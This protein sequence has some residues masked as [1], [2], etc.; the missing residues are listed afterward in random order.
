[1]NKRL[2]VTIMLGRDPSY[3]FVRKSFEAYASRVGA[4]LVCIREH[5]GDY[6]FVSEKKSLFLKA[7]FEKL[8]LEKYLR[9][10]E[11]VLYL[12]AD[13]LITPGARDIFDVYSDPRNI[14]ML[15]EGAVSC[16]RRELD[17]IS[18]HL[19][20]P[21]HDPHYFNAGV[22]LISRESG[23]L[24]FV[25][26][27]VLT[28]LAKNSNFPEQ[29]YMA[30]SFHKKGSSIKTILPEFNRMGIFGDGDG[31]GDGDKRLLA[32]FIHYAGNS[33]CRKKHRARTIM[34]DYCRIYRYTPTL[35]E[36]I[37]FAAL[38]LYKKVF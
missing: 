19:G 13:I 21:I 4:D 15:D 33:Y 5:S 3:H 37:R 27:D 24:G 23:F 30:Y 35:A 25:D 26:N 17:L 2:I 31:D 36:R 14:Y 11:R 38:D 7:I 22:I 9:Y 20:R 6:D 34:R 32:S 12:D 10:Y 16:R 8:N 1:M 18:E 28:F 29:T